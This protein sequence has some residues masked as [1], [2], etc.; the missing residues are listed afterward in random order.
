MD[1]GLYY[2]LAAVQV[3]VACSGE[4][5]NYFTPV[6]LRCT[7]HEAEGSLRRHCAVRLSVPLVI[8]ID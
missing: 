3:T 7:G 6:V 5:R 2:L 8:A 1:E 4:P